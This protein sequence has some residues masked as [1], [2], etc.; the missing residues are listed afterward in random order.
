MWSPC[1]A[2]SPPDAKPQRVSRLFLR[3]RRDADLAPFFHR[4]V[5]DGFSAPSRLLFPPQSAPSLDS[6]EQ[7]EWSEVLLLQ[8]DRPRSCGRAGL[9]AALRRLQLLLWLCR[10][11][12]IDASRRSALHVE[13]QARCGAEGSFSRTQ[14]AS[15]HVFLAR[16]GAILGKEWHLRS[17]AGAGPRRL[18]TKSAKF[19]P[20]FSFL[21]PTPHPPLSLFFVCRFSSLYDVSVVLVHVQVRWLICE[22]RGPGQVP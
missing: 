10:R 15:A 11:I 21:T 12:V 2:S 13:A 22:T 3:P 17:V 9:A 8:L 6:G 4:A 14:T 1:T 20:S 16:V 19:A 18:P 7:W 5:S